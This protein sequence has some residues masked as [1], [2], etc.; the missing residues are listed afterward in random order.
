MSVDVV[1]ALALILGVLFSVRRL[2]AQK[3]R[4][5]EFPGVE[6]EQFS[7]WQRAEIRAATVLSTACFAK[8]LLDLGL[9]WLVPRTGISRQ[10][11]WPAAMVIDVAWLV[12]MLIGL[13]LRAQARRLREALQRRENTPSEPDTSG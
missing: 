7:K 10:V 9:Q 5:D 2:S 11:Q 8:I 4:V 13:R 3:A 1:D 6:L 12:V